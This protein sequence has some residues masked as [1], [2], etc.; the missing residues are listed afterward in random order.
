MSIAVHLGY[1]LVLF[2]D[3]G[4][5]C[6]HFE[7]ILGSIQLLVVVVLCRIDE[8]TSMP[9][10]TSTV[11]SFAAYRDAEAVEAQFLKVL[12]TEICNPEAVKPLSASLFNRIDVLERLASEAKAKKETELLEG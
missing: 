5:H 4:L 6:A 12:D 11:I 8:E 3:C 10:K 1:I 2:L 9:S 7:P